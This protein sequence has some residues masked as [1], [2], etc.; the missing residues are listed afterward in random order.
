MNE[1]RNSDL[2]L[3]GGHPALD[4]VNT[5]A[6]RGTGTHREYLATPDDL[7][8]W[9]RRASVLDEV[10]AA[11]VARAWTDPDAAAQALDATIDIRE[12]TYT[13]LRTRLDGDAAGAAP[14]LARLTRRWAAAT[15]RSDLM[16]D[17]GDI[18]ARLVV[19]TAPATLVADRLADAAVDLL[20]TVDLRRLRVCPLA[21]GGCGWLFLDRS[22]NGSR[23]WCAMADCGT[24][25]KARRLTAKRR[26]RR[27]TVGG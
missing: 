5:V 25:A 19:G 10:D 18:A 22:R 26:A 20:R 23:R 1:P 15:A 13:A 16:P 27:A 9:A 7:L 21:E 6:P 11:A 3:V 14:A 24:H 12:A 8:A 4:L 17:P 2:R